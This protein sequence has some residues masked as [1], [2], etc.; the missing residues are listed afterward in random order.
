MTRG[1]HLLFYKVGV[2]DQGHMLDVGIPCIHDSDNR[3]NYDRQTLYTYFL[4]R[5][6][7]THLF[8]RSVVKGQGHMLNI[9]VNLCKLDKPYLIANYNVITLFNST[10]GRISRLRCSC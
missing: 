2:K 1:Q 10:V 4:W 3:F 8:S 7:D 6:D 5:E 9:V